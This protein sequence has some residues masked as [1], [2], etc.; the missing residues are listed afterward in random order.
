MTPPNTTLKEE[1]VKRISILRTIQTV[2]ATLV[3][4][5]IPMGFSSAGAVEV[6]GLCAEGICCE[7]K[8]SIC[9]VGGPD[10]SDHYKSTTG[11]CSLL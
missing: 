1:L 3:L 4:A 2:S 7:E 5:A 6:D 8:R 9:N 10:Q 11:K